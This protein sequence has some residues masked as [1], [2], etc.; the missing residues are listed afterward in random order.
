MVIAC[1]FPLIRKR[2]S[3]K[4]EAK[5][6]GLWYRGPTFGIVCSMKLPLRSV[7]QHL[8]VMGSTRF[9]SK[10]LTYLFWLWHIWNWLKRVLG[11]QISALSF[12]ETLS[13]VQDKVQPCSVLFLSHFVKSLF[14]LPCLFFCNFEYPWMW[15]FCRKKGFLFV[16]LNKTIFSVGPLRERLRLAV[17]MGPNWVSLPPPY[18]LRTETDPVPKMV[19]FLVFRIPD[20]GQIRNPVILSIISA[21]GVEGI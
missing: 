15:W 7:S 2:S 10:L 17:S 19:C 8:K 9:I 14:F 5:P 11:N 13:K 21:F 3:Q 1:L 4:A 20:D 12:K 6:R 16:G 18:H